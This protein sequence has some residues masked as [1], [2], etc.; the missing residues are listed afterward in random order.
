MENSFDYLCTLLEFYRKCASVGAVKV[1]RNDTDIFT[2][3]S[4]KK[5]FF[6]YQKTL[7]INVKRVCY[8]YPNL[9]LSNIKKLEHIF[10]NYKEHLIGL[11]QNKK[12]VTFY[13][14]DSTGK[15][16]HKCK[17]KYVS[18]NMFRIPKDKS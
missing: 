1:Q 10:N 16:R 9:A 5:K 18:I 17:I 12:Y 8:I 6:H 3:Y 11:K 14:Y 7:A 13:A 2:C 4:N 15:C